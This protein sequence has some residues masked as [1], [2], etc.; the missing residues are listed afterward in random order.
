MVGL[1]SGTCG[2]AEGQQSASMQKMAEKQRLDMPVI[3]IT[4]R[5]L[6]F[7]WMRVH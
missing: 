2:H 1:G 6:D 3:V 4:L 7:S 5:E